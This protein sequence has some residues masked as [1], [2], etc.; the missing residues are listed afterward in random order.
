MECNKLLRSLTNLVVNIVLSLQLAK[1]THHSISNELSIKFRVAQ[2]FPNAKPL[3][4]Y[5]LYGVQNVTA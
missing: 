1:K 5:C 3:I 2:C 4:V